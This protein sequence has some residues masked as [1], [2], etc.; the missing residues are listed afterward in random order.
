MKGHM[1]ALILSSALFM[2]CIQLP[3]I[4]VEQITGMWSVMEVAMEEYIAIL[5]E[6]SYSNFNYAV[7]NDWALEYSEQLR[8]SIASFIFI[9]FVP[10]PLTL[11]LSQ[12]WLRVIRR[13]EIYTDMIFSGFSDFFR[14]VAMDALRRMLII[15]W[16]FLF[17]IPGIIAWYRYSQAF[18]LMVDNPGIKPYEALTLSKYYMQQNKGSRFVLDLTFVGWLV[19][20]I[21]AFYTIQVIAFSILI[22]GGNEI[23]LFTQAIVSVILSSIVFAPLFAYRGVTSAEY[24]HRVICKDPQS[25]K[26]PLAL[27]PN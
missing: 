8:F 4:L 3:V 26:D 6:L 13:N 22:A 11:G 15:L 23:G 2:L 17:I 24:Y 7:L 12:I 16:S 20:S 21:V 5:S 27:P 14:I 10:G 19:V 25:F 18:F 1:G 9:L